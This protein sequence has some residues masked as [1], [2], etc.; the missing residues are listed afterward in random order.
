MKK[1]YNLFVLAILFAC[2][3]SA[4]AIYWEQT[5]D[6]PVLVPEAGVAYFIA[7]GGAADYTQMAYL[8]TEGKI[9][10]TNAIA[11][12]D[13]WYFESAGENSWKVYC[14]VNGEKH[15]LAKS[16]NVGSGFVTTTHSR[17]NEIQVTDAV[18]AA[19]ADEA[20][21][22]EY[23]YWTTKDNLDGTQVFLIDANG[24]S[25]LS[26]NGSTASYGGVS[27]NTTWRL[28]PAM[29]MTGN[30]YLNAI[31]NELF[32]EGF[33]PD[34][35]SVGINP[36]DYSE[37]ALNALVEAYENAS[38]GSGDDAECIQL[39]EGLIKAYE[40]LKASFVNFGEGYYIFT[41]YRS[42][43]GAMFDNTN[44]VSGAKNNM[45]TT[46]DPA[47]A[48]THTQTGGNEFSIGG[49]DV[50][51][52]ENDD[53]WMTSAAAP[54]FIWKVTKSDKEGMFYIQNWKTKRY[55]GTPGAD[56][57]SNTPIPTVAEP[58]AAFN[59]APS[60]YK[61]DAGETCWTFY[62]DELTK[63]GAWG[64]TTWEMGGLH[65]PGD[66]LNMVTWDSSKE[67]SCWVPRKIDEAMLQ[68]IE[69]GNKQATLN[70]NLKVLV[71]E[72]N[73]AIENSK[74][75][76]IFDSAT[77]KPA[78]NLN[79][80]ESLLNE[81]GV[82]D[83]LVNDA[84]QLYTNAQE[85]S[86]GP[87]ENLLDGDLTTFFH[88]AWNSDGA[89]QQVAVIDPETGEPM[90]DPETGEEVL[91]YPA[92]NI[93][94]DLLDQPQE[95]ITVMW[96]TRNGKPA[97]RPVGVKVY[98]SNDE[99][100]ES[101]IDGIYK[102]WTEIGE[103]EFH[104][105]LNNKIV[106]GGETSNNYVG[107]LSAKLGA[108]Y[109]YVRIDVITTGGNSGNY[110]KFFNG[111]E[112]RVYPGV[113]YEYK[114]DEANSPYEGVA[115]GIKQTLNEVLDI[116]NTE[117]EDE[118][119]TQGTIDA[120][121]A[122]FDNFKNNLPDPTTVQNL[123]KEALAQ[124]DAAQEGDGVG[125]FAVGAAAELRAVAEGIQVT[126][127]SS[128]A[129]IQEAL[130][131]IK[132]AIAAFN[133]KLNKPVNGKYYYIKSATEAGAKWLASIEEPTEE[134][135]DQA[136]TH[137]ADND[138]VGTRNAEGFNVGWGAE[139]MTDEIEDYLGYVWQSETNADGT[140]SLKHILT[141]YYMGG[142]Y[143]NDENVELVPADQKGKF[144]Y[145]SAKVAGVVNIVFAENVYLNAQ[146]GTNNMVTWNSASGNDNSAF[147]FEEAEAIKDGAEYVID[148][149]SANG[150]RVMTLPVAVSV[151][152]KG[153]AAY[154]VL[155]VKG[156]GENATIELKAITGA[157]E[158]GK[159]FIFDPDGYAEAYFE[160]AKIGAVAEGKVANGL[161]GVLVDTELN[162]DGFL[163]IQ[164][165][166]KRDS[167]GEVTE[168]ITNAVLADKGAYISAG[169]GCFTAEM[170]ATTEKGD[171]SIACP[172]G[173]PAAKAEGIQA[174][175]VRI[176][177]K[178]S[179]D[180]QGRRVSNAH[181]GIYVKDGQKYIVK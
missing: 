22:N 66:V 120:L 169:R 134:Q 40:A 11:E 63:K 164:N 126:G 157:I 107:V 172:D 76:T 52:P 78:E 57:A 83:G 130:A 21:A 128:V 9:T 58:N 151:P 46:T 129:E 24:S 124:A 54:Y 20:A 93:C 73:Q 144:D 133:G 143:E 51:D 84:S 27:A 41:T 174:A 2:A 74:I 37:D 85:Q 10:T 48:I 90:I 152:A 155:G 178:G 32:P 82:A 154:E 166:I 118:L 31:I 89:P 181:K 35:Y 100:E 96:Y 64:G 145:Q 114:Y 30:N 102:E 160:S 94:F 29:Q 158:A 117:L 153:C 159:P 165:Q 39:A 33:D 62:S 42:S 18:Y 149:S 69:E 4:N 98:A 140:F 171:I 163:V 92:H 99:T 148:L 119:A 156:E 17:I 139:A 38:E 19:D 150:L 71:D 44:N 132:A 53:A 12:R 111:A 87:I 138:F 7:N 109:R 123:V 101:E 115:A 97:D 110:G 137:Y 161:M 175:I 8:N 65:A 49:W 55:I 91:A 104:F 79:V 81:E 25:Y 177:T 162:Q 141:G 26:T 147:T 170:T 72:V 105:D 122:A 131:K 23:P 36:G 116:A 146:P 16:A 1:I 61:N 113:K 68:Q 167:E 112:V 5:G 180:L 142:G 106:L 125:Y 50:Y 77:G 135:Q 56:K 6:E 75:Y 34:S 67:G 127:T 45:Y 70:Y 86:E 80:V 173:A 3:G 121:Q 47:I 88:S 60:T 59:M 179:F 136:I 14:L 103:N 43:T 15:Y 176:A 28:I 108:Q 168:V 95:A 13:V